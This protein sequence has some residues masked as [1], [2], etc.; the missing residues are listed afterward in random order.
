MNKLELPNLNRWRAGEQP[1]EE[2]FND[3]Q[4]SYEFLLDPPT[5]KVHKTTTQS[6]TADTFTVVTWNEVVE[7]NCKPFGIGYSTAMW[8]PGSANVLTAQL[9][10][11]YEV[12]YTITWNQRTD[13]GRRMQFF[14]INGDFAGFYQR[15]R[16]DVWHMDDYTTVNVIY[17]VF[18][19]VG[20]WIRIWVI[21]NAGATASL[22][23]APEPGRRSQFKMKWVS[24]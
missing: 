11:W 19:N 16:R 1:D 20:D 23:T 9:G 3:L 7:D 15:G 8:D 5:V 10:G 2:M 14:E 12:Q 17:P 6:I 13:D 21:H 24:L 4:D 22:V 18:L